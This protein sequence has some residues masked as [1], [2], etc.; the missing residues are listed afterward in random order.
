LGHW[1][2][3]I[4]SNKLIWSDE[5]YR[6]FDL[7]P[8]E[9]GASYE[10]F[11]DA[12]HPDDREFVDRAY[13]D[14]LK[15]KTKYDI[16]HRL[17]LKDGTVKYVHERCETEYDNGGN[18][19]RSLGTVLDITERK[20]ASE[21]LERIKWILTKS[22]NTEKTS[23]EIEE[24]YKQDYGDLTEL[25]DSGLIKNMVGK[26][27]LVKVAGDYLDLLQSSGAIYEKDGKYALGIFSSGW[28]RFLDRA[29]RKLCGT[30]DNAEALDSGKWLCH[31][32]CWSNASKSCIE[33]GR[34]ADIECNGGIR[35]YAVPI[36][37]GREIV[38]SMNFGYG[39]PPQDPQKFQEIAE[40][41]K[42]GVDELLQQAGQYES[43]PQFIIDI[44]K[45]R[46]LTS[47]RLIGEIIERK[48]A[49]EILKETNKSYERLTD[50]A[51]EAIFKVKAEGGEV[52]YI[53]PAAE[54]IFGYSI[55]EWQSDPALAFKIIHSDYKEKQKRIIEEI[56]KTK[57]K[58]K[59]VVLGWIAKDGRLIIMEYTII[60]ILD[61]DGN[62]TYFESIGRDITDRKKAE[63]ELIR[64]RQHLETLVEERTVRL[65]KTNQQLEH[66]V[67]KRKETE[68]YLKLSHR[69]LEITNQRT[70]IKPLLQEFLTEIKEFT[71][72]AA[73]GI[74]MLDKD[75]NIP[76]Q[77]HEGFSEKFFESECHLSIKEN[78]CFC[79]MIVLAEF[80]PQFSFYTNGGS[81]Y[82]NDAKEFWTSIPDDFK[83]KDGLR[84][85]CKESGY[86][87]LTLIPIRVT[88][89][90]IGLIQLVDYQKDRFPL[91]LIETLEQVTLSLGS[92]MQ[93]LEIQ[94]NLRLQSEITTNMSEGV[95]LIR[96]A[97]GIIVYSNPKFAEMFGY[98]PGEMVGKHV[99]IVNAP[100][101]KSPEETAREISEAINRDGFWRG[102]VK[103]IRKDGTEF[104]CHASVSVFNHPEHGNVF[105]SVH[106]DISERKQVEEEILKA[107]E[108]W[109]QTF[110]TV[111]DAIMVL[112]KDQRIVRI[113]KAMLNLIGRSPDECI[114]QLC[115]DVVHGTDAPPSFCP[116]KKLLA[117]GCAHTQEVREDSLGGDFIVSTVPMHDEKKQLMGSVHVAHDITERKRAEEARLSRFRSLA[118]MNQI[119]KI[120]QETS[121]IK[122]MMDNVLQKTLSMFQCDRA[123]ILFPVDPDAPTFRIPMEHTTS[124][125]P[126]A[127]A[128][129][130]DLPMT[131]ETAQAMR[132]ALEAD[133]PVVYDPESGL[134]VNDVSKRFSVQ[135]V[136][137]MAIYPKIGKPWLFGLH[138]CSYPRVW[139]EEDQR[140]F[141]DIGYRLADALSSLLFLKDLQESEEHFR[142]LVQE[143]GDVIIVLSPD[144]RILEFNREAET[145]YGA[146]RNK[147]L[148]KNYL[149][150]FITDEEAKRLVTADCE[151]VLSGQPT[152]AFENK[153]QSVDGSERFFSWNVNRLLSYEGYPVVA[154]ASGHDIT[155]RKPIP[156]GRDGGNDRKYCPSMETTP[157]CPQYSFIQYKRLFR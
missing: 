1:E 79:S 148:G 123:W 93:R 17:L 151:K 36:R 13:K 77:A 80:D 129:G 117:D 119:N 66:E 81:F 7:K 54:R 154:I 53:N 5:I 57:K 74:R 120:I 111:P 23:H 130:K 55:K 116:H 147:V 125:Y 97:D 90:V 73:I 61:K 84:N 8:Q 104:W 141:Q 40:K 94:E 136:I 64:Y 52:F 100:T 150:L 51:D 30:M 89:K 85:A 45:N 46:L 4:V 29:A 60:P 39:D 31:E 82:T 48:Q 144:F 10:A 137:D 26:D 86:G 78:H 106:Q 113:N 96:A 139:T 108:E 67:T 105:V 65:T 91:E 156:P 35:I 143:A 68:E 102:E 146:K 2:F 15:N 152:K 6:I 47:A 115:Y 25:N 28:C 138:Q 33:K 157:K 11:L 63:D 122:Q 87:S 118:H 121:D 110:E 124:R 22:I 142:T 132:T 95:Y 59:N 9:F 34:P 12:V 70:S 37:A 38:G 140:L 149:D 112:D 44:A 134:V 24:C 126:G 16:V 21:E 62:I 18:P 71:N 43:R 133:G 14:S 83:Q 128:A 114:G 32:S 88:N 99:S 155:R 92:A 75:G 107:K 72:C 27:L 127:L 49:E 41:Y 20:S 56:N 50:N 98:R 19:L 69:L 3:D 109:E 76:Y 58:I 153:I 101:D 145:I 42:V 131:P 103:N 135:S